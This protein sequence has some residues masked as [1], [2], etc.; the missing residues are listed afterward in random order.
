[1][2]NLDNVTEFSCKLHINDEG[3]KEFCEFIHLGV[4]LGKN[5]TSADEDRERTMQ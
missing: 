2:E 1:M 3:L 5:G 4:V